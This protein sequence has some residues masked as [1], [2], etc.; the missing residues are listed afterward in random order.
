MD[1]LS[2]KNLK[3]FSLL[4]IIIVLAITMAVQMYE[5]IPGVLAAFTLYVLLRDWYFK[6][7]IIKGW[8]KWLAAVVFIIGSLLVFVLPFA[9]LAEILIP[10]II[11]IAHNR[12]QI[13]S[14]VTTVTGKI[15][16]YI[17]SF[18]FGPQ[19]LN[20]LLNRA[21]AYVPG[22]LGA[23]MN[24][25][26]NL[27]LVFF[28]L[29]FMLVEGRRME[30]QV[31]NFLPFKEE[32]IDDIWA[33]T[34]MMVVSN[35]IGIPVLAIIQAIAAGIGYYLFGVPEPLLWAVVT[36]IFSILPVVG[37]AIVWIPLTVYLFGT[38]HN[39]QGV[40]MLIYSIAV[41]TNIDNVARFT[42]LK[43]LGDVHP[44]VT[45]VGLMVGV[46]IFGFMGLIFGPLM[47]SYLML[48]VKVYRVEFAPRQRV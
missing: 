42:L 38:G 6:L 29:Y 20:G 32:S 16:Q 8:K 18:T 2:N 28:L 11:A 17:P 41:I 23:T 4:V 40:G 15:H 12:A 35:A 5:F 44:V 26:T 33:A 10:K 13:D 7:T 3:Q 30:R 9:L 34:R 48:L 45:V 37:T 46:P 27:V 25:I 14:A 24:L 39:A 36:G 21:T 22:L 1:I 31:Q 47:V 19:Q 43:K